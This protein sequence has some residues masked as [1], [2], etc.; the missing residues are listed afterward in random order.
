M[1]EDD[2]LPIDQKAIL[3]HSPSNRRRW[4]AVDLT[5]RLTSDIHTW[6]KAHQG[7][8]DVLWLGGLGRAGN[9]CMNCV[10]QTCYMN[11][12]CNPIKI[13]G[14]VHQSS[15]YTDHAKWISP[16]GAR[17]LL[18]CTQKCLRQEA[19]GVDSVIKAVCLSSLELR[20]H[21]SGRTCLNAECTISGMTT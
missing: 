7:S 3:R 18:S 10:N 6:I 5:K 17:I 12:D 19:W 11:E 8:H 9:S 14:S 1:F 4:S 13:R 15:Y 16:R 21:K 20:Y 2:V